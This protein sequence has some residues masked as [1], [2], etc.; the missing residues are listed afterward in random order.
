MC[1]QGPVLVEGVGADHRDELEVLGSVF[2]FFR[3]LEKSRSREQRVSFF[4]LSSSRFALLVFVSKSLSLPLSYPC[5]IACGETA[6]LSSLRNLEPSSSL[7]SPAEDLPIPKLE[8]PR[9]FPPLSEANSPR[10]SSRRTSSTGWCA[11]AAEGGRAPASPPLSLPPLSFPHASC[12]P[13]LRP[14]PP[15]RPCPRRPRGTARRRSLPPEPGP[16]R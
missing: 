1:R 5:S 13:R 12:I 9:M 4:F 8:E 11:A 16:W 15:R 6:C 10:P 3:F 2:S 14:R 7:P